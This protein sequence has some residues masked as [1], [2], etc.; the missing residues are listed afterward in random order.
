MK[1]NNNNFIILLFII[2]LFILTT[3]NI[4]AACA[5][6][7]NDEWIVCNSCDCASY[8]GGLQCVD[9]PKT[10]APKVEVISPNEVYLI[11]GQKKYRLASD[12]VQAKFDEELLKYKG[13]I[14]YRQFEKILAPLIAKKGTISKTRINKIKNELA[15]QGGDAIFD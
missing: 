13:K 3:I 4:N 9:L 2:S 15:V 11:V 6:K 1:S 5:I 7:F 12:E 10:K 8:T 14:N